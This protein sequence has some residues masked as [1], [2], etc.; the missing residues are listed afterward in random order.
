MPERQP[1]PAN[2]LRTMASVSSPRRERKPPPAC[3]AVQR[4]G[5]PSAAVLFR[6]GALGFRVKLNAVAGLFQVILPHLPGVFRNFLFGIQLFLLRILGDFPRLFI[7]I[8]NAFDHGFHS[9]RPAFPSAWTVIPGPLRLVLP[10][11]LVGS[12]PIMMQGN[13]AVRTER[14]RNPYKQVNSEYIP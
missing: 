7:H 10:A 12:I 9:C 1:S 5:R 8:N 3:E 14:A 4:N 11:T 2:T 13:R 6:G